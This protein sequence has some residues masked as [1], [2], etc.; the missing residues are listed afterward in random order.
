MEIYFC[1]GKYPVVQAP[2]VEKVSFF[3]CIT[4]TLLFKKKST[5]NS[6]QFFLYN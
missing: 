5:D 4:F 6:T 3:H 2:F 1:V